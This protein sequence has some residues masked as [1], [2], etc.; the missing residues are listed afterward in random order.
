MKHNKHVPSRDPK[1]TATA[2]MIGRPTFLNYDI[3][4]N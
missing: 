2:G 3:I 4:C 1:A